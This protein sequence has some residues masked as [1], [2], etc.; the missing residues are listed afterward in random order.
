PSFNVAMIGLETLA[1]PR[2]GVSAILA[3]AGLAPAML[4]VNNSSDDA[5]VVRNNHIHTRFSIEPFLAGGSE[6][7]CQATDQSR[8]R[9]PPAQTHLCHEAHFSREA[10]SRVPMREAACRRA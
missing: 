2:M 6:E 1:S 3:R 9:T 7:T 4:A 10:S 8:E 5:R